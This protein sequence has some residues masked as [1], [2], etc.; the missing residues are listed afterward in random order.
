MPVSLDA[1]ANYLP[2]KAFA[3][4]TSQKIISK[5]MEVLDLV[6]VA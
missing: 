3:L 1:R 5:E 2:Q 6:A 4:G